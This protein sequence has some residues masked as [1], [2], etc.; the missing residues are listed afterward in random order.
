MS[1]SSVVT[2]GYFTKTIPGGDRCVRAI[3]RDAWLGRRD[4][5]C[6]R[7]LQ[8]SAICAGSV[9]VQVVDQVVRQPIPFLLRDVIEARRENILQSPTGLR[10]R[11]FGVQPDHLQALDT[12][13]VDDLDRYAPVLFRAR[14]AG[15]PH[16]GTPQSTPRPPLP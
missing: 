11:R 9:M 14:R 15:T 12:P 8:S 6:S 7:R 16:P 4:M 2:K 5:R 1:T 3:G 10:C 13:V